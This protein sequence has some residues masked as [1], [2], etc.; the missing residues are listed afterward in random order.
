M[1]VTALSYWLLT[2]N[3]KHFSSEFLNIKIYPQYKTRVIIHIYLSIE[4]Q[5]CKPTLQ[6]VK[7]SA[8]LKW[9]FHNFYK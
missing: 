1:I 4:N 9:N 6:P 2:R 3:E 8:N 7:V 5:L